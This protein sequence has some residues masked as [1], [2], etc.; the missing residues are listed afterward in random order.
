MV[1]QAP[2]NK[3]VIC[4]T[5]NATPTEG[6][7]AQA[8]PLTSAAASEEAVPAAPAAPVVAAAAPEND[9]AKELNQIAP[10]AG[11][12]VEKAEAAP[13]P[14]VCAVPQGSQQ[15]TQEML[16][17]AV[18]INKPAAN[19][20]VTYKVAAGQDYNLTFS[21]KDALVENQGENLVIRFADGSVII[22]EQFDNVASN[23][24][25]IVD[26]CQVVSGSDYTQMAGLA[27]SLAEIAPAAGGQA[28][29]ATGAQANTAPGNSG[30]GF[31]QFSDAGLPNGPNPLGPLGATALSYRLIDGLT[32][33]GGPTRADGKP[34]IGLG[35]PLNVVDETDGGATNNGIFNTPRVNGGNFNF[36]L[37]PDGAGFVKIIDGPVA[38]THHGQPILVTISADGLTATGT[39]S[40]GETIFTFSI[41]PN[42]KTYTFTQFGSLDHPD[43][44]DPNEA[45]DLPFVIRVQDADGDYVDGTAIM[46]VLDD[47]PSAVTPATVEV[48]ETTGG[49]LVAGG[50]VNF[51]YGGDG[52]GSIKLIGGPAGLTS[53]GNAVNVSVT[54]TVITGTAGGV[55]VFTLTLNP[56]TGAWDYQQFAPL[57]HGDANNPDDAL[58]L[59][60]T[61][62]VTDYD[63]DSVDTAI[64]VVC[65]R[66][67]GRRNRWL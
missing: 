31:S 48:D 30:A 7:D 49:T 54:D 12:P 56:A 9:V 29:A 57:D 38:L 11:A 4:D 61:V 8:M 58:G 33:E 64:N 44:T 32:P 34:S 35:T 39:T 50:V 62:R 18:T 3:A 46:R 41:D 17:N 21:T 28:A 2:T 55:T 14:E 63:G 26:G 1:E 45:L 60:F 52:A 20:T 36:D 42:T 51:S 10:A 67:L 37:G 5:P 47:A 16:A 13:S 66:Q 22:L 43:P 24:H 27:S 59:G 23:N 25:I 6:G 15:A 53:G 40:G 65:S 19:E